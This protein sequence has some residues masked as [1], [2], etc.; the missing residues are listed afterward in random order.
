MWSEERVPNVWTIFYA[1]I[2]RWR[3]V[4]QTQ[5]VIKFNSL[6]IL[7]LQLLPGLGFFFKFNY[8]F[9]PPHQWQSQTI[10]QNN[11]NNSTIT[12]IVFKSIENREIPRI[13]DY[14]FFDSFITIATV[15]FYFFNQHTNLHIA[16]KKRIIQ[17]PPTVHSFKIWK[18]SKSWFM[19]RLEQKIIFI[20]FLF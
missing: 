3:C 6:F 1:C 19:W 16:F 10:Q 17:T 12:N 11:T 18:S 4:N 20:L 7:R 15:E 14:A 9:P 13:T 8:F 5:A 2:C